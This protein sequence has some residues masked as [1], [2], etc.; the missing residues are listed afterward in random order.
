MK[1]LPDYIQVE[2][3][4]VKYIRLQVRASGQVRMVVP[5]D[6]D[7]ADIVRIYRDRQ[8][9]IEAKR[10]GWRQRQ[11]TARPPAGKFWLFGEAHGFEL[12][13]TSGEGGQIDSERKIVRASVDLS[14]PQK[15]ERWYR[16]QAHAYLPAR[17]AELGQR[18]GFVWHRVYIRD[19]RT[20]WGNCSS[21]GNISL[22]WRLIRLP[23][24][25]SDYII[26]H[27]LTHLRVMNHSREF[28]ERLATICP[29]YQK[30][31]HYLKEEMPISFNLDYS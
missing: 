26:L 16:Q 2:Y 4:Q 23:V 18:H 7:E 13:P 15:L 22:N 1:N 3:R 19:Q 9:W 28:W 25:V 21:L 29:D 27:E 24:W 11:E 31:E 12:D 10:D 30:A 17:V 14:D 8:A 6:C 20:K 5:P